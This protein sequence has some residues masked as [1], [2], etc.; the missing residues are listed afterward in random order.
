MQTLLLKLYL[1]AQVLRENDAQ[2]LIEYALLAALIALA[3]TTATSGVA[4]SVANAF[5]TIG[6][7]VTAATT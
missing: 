4:A 6:N 2:D 3:A 5:T 7:A 1:K